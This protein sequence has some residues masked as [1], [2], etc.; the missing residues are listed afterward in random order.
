[1]SKVILITENR[2]AFEI[3]FPDK[4]T[5]VKIWPDGKVDGIEEPFVVVNHIPLLMLHR[6]RL[7]DPV[8]EK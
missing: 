8:A 1:M 6:E 5:W 4:G 2:P 3:F 7:I